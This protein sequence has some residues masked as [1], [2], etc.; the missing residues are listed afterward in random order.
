VGV[1]DSKDRGGPVLDFAGTTWTSFV[2]ALKAGSPP[3]A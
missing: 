3:P 1:R 2:A